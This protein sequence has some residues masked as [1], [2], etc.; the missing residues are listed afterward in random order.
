MIAGQAVAFV[1]GLLSV[2]VVW[3]FARDLFDVRVANIAALVFAILPVPRSNASDA[4][5]DTPHLVF[6]LL[7]AWLASAAVVRGRL[8]LL[9]GAGAASGVAYWI[10]P[11]GLEVAIVAMACVVWQGVR[12]QWSI[13]RVALASAALAGTVLLIAAPY[14]VL[15]GKI[16]SKQHT[17]AHAQMAKTFIAKL[18]TAK[19]AE[20]PNAPT[21]S[22]AEETVTE[23]PN[24]VPTSA[25]QTAIAPAS[26][27][28][29]ASVMLVVRRA[30][31]AV[32]S[33]V[34]S[35]C[36]G[37]KWVFI[38]LY[39]VGNIEL[40]RRK[41]RALPIVFVAL[42]ATAHVL[43]LLG[44]FMLS[45]YIA[46]RHV[47]PLVALAMPFTALGV[48]FVGERLARARRLP[49]AYGT[50]ATLGLCS[51]IVL[52]Y[53]LRPFCQEFVPVIEAFT[54]WVQA[55]AQP[56]AGIVSNSPYTAF[57]GALPTA[58]LCSDSPTLDVALAKAR[59]DAHYD[60]VVLHVGAHD[61]RPE[62]IAELQSRYR[63]VQLFEHPNSSAHP[64]K[65][66][67]FQAKE[68]NAHHTAR[69][70]PS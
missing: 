53:T 32:S 54:R 64:K 1:C 47:L 40:A 50:L 58:Y 28:W 33:F 63:Q 27:T 9:A 69:N 30:C 7:G 18:G 70:S 19:P 37:F 48:L 11:E 57:Y 62:W 26:E 61:Y 52:P 13:R 43:V 41:P 5:S 42:L 65:V 3:L 8:W 39:L 44:V 46:H 31:K 21:P 22:V 17:I 55:H 24:L 45:G 34:N 56:G 59:R 68:A 35:I 4:M 10:R 2:G 25:A 67:V 6:Y 16:T 12:S 14:A 51:A 36:Q 66:L 49:A 29:R 15:A 23:P 20:L 38:P 60:F